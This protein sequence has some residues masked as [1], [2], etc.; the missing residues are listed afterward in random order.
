MEKEW[1]ELIGRLFAL[2]KRHAQT[3]AVHDATMKEKMVDWS[4]W[5]RRNLL[6]VQGLYTLIKRFTAQ[7]YFSAGE[8]RRFRG[9]TA[10]FGTQLHHSH[11]SLMGQLYRMYRG[12]A[13]LLLLQR[14]LKDQT[15]QALV[16]QGYTIADYDLRLNENRQLYISLLKREKDL[17]AQS[18]KLGYVQL[19]NLSVPRN[20]YLV[21]C[22]WG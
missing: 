8:K 21:P 5:E 15:N 10:E 3:V 7:R 18:D 16:K 9:A 13:R 4:V 12:R 11:S 14:A 20:L 6:G 1:D 19:S 22:L 17:E 2:F